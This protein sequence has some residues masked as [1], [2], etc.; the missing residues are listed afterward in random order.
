MKNIML[1]IVLISNAVYAE[2]YLF[3]VNRTQYD[4]KV[5]E[6][7]TNPENPDP[8]NCAAQEVT[9]NNCTATTS[10]IN[11]GETIEIESSDEENSGTVSL[12]CTNGLLSQSNPTCETKVDCFEP[13]SVGLTGNNGECKDKLIVDN[14][15]LVNLVNSSG[16]YSSSKIFTGQVTNMASL[17]SGKSV[18]N[19]ITGWNTSNVTN[20]ANMFRGSSSFNQDISNWNTGK[21]INMAGMFNTAISFNQPIGKWNVSNVQIFGQAGG[22]FGMF[23]MATSF[24]QP[25]NNWNVSKAI[26][27]TSLF[28]G[29]TAFNQ[30]LNNW[31]VS[32]VTNMGYMF[33]GATAFNQPL[34]NW[35]TL[36]V[37]NMTGL[38]NGASIFNQNISNWNVNSVSSY[39]D[40]KTGSSLTNENTPSKFN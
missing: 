39:T 38:F 27:M 32:S 21:V 20:M 5:I 37:I 17:F 36:N 10:I 8:N 6:G 3:K 29:A 35:N 18:L 7:Q 26:N 4:F 12:T 25:L 9:W 19:D 28:N 31:N 23:R 33:N 22:A 16:D 40:F 34:N 11:N 30:P 14:A 15:M 13:S 1:L 2:E 24:N